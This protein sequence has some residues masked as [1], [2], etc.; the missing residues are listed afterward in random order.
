MLVSMVV[1]FWR[2]RALKSAA[3]RYDS[4]ALAADA[5]NF[6]SDLWTSAAVLAGLA[7]TWAGQRYGYS[8][9]N[10]ADTV[11][12]CIV[13][14]ALV[15]LAWRVG[16]R[17]AGVLLDEAPA[18]LPKDL[19]SLVLEV[20]GVVNVER[21]RVR[22]A[23]SKHFV[24]MRLAVERTLTLER[25][26]QVRDEVS[27][28]VL[29]RLP[30]ADVVVDTHPGRPASP[31]I[32]EQLRAIA[33]RQNVGLHDLAVYDVGGV[34]DVELHLEVDEQLPLKQAHDLVSTIEAQMRAEI[35]QIRQIITHIEPEFADIPRS[36]VLELQRI[37][38]RVERIA[39]TTDGLLD[40]HD[41]QLRLSQGHLSLSC[42]C[43]F[44]DTMPVAR[45]HEIVTAVEARIK[46]E[47]PQLLK[48][49]IHTEP[50]SDNRR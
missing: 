24:D 2:S 20:P 14:G 47:I 4:D 23:G 17:T 39:Q 42:H 30:G 49:T 41:I 1:D 25:A 8:A 29:D 6:S 40:C 27:V 22:K 16:R 3:V 35:P 10:H 45:V 13:S 7:V 18:D 48:V 36:D 28:H 5:L 31:N 50:G 15:W 12:A 38:R 33:Q 34:F 19:R 44:P 9:L 37:R 26:R 43:S 11:A 21:L 46:R 32:F